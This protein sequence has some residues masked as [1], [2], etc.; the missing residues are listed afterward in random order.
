MKHHTW[1][2]WDFSD[3]NWEFED[4]TY[5]SPPTCLHFTGAGLTIVT[6]KLADSLVL[7][8]GKIVTARRLWGNAPDHIH[9]RNQEPDGSSSMANCYHARFTSML[10]T[11]F[12]RVNDV[13][14]QL[15]EWE[16]PLTLYHW[17]TLTVT[18]WLY[19]APYQPDVLRTRIYMLDHTTSQE[20]QYQHDDEANQWADS[21]VNRCGIA[22]LSLPPANY[23]DDTEIWR[24]Q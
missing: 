13:D 15:A 8:E 10:V 2:D 12:R 23:I 20:W 19:K 16:Y 17:F 21:E 14:T 18:W 5:I 24:P 7:P 3:A 4:Y 6:C 1:T 11:L 9:F 22:G